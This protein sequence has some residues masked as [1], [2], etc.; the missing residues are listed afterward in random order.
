MP[1]VGQVLLTAHPQQP[2]PIMRNQNI[3]FFLGHFFQELVLTTHFPTPGSFTL[4]MFLTEAGLK[5]PVFTIS[6]YG[7]SC[8]YISFLPHSRSISFSLSI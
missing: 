7:S 4:L 8:N 1:H 5:L 3:N 6:V 2:D